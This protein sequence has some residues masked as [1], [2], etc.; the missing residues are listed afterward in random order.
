[1][2]LSMFFFTASFNLIIPELNGF[3]TQ[4]DGAH[5]KGLIIGLFTVSA[6][7]SRP[8]SGKLSDHI[9]RKKVMFIGG[10][11]C[12]LVSLLYPISFSIWFFLL[13][14]FLHGFSAGFFPTGATALVTDILPEETRGTGMG[15]WGTFISLGIGFGQ[16]LSSITASQFGMNGLFFTA[17]LLSVGSILLL[18]KVEE[19]LVPVER[20]QSKQLLIKSDEIIE[21]NVTPVAII[22]FLSAICSGIII[23]LSPE[24]SDFLHIPAKGWFF[25][26]YVL[27]T[28]GIRLFAGKVSDKFGRRETLLVGMIILA[29]SMVIIGFSHSTLWFTLSAILFGVA[30]GISSPT[31][32]AWT[33]DLSPEHRR[34]IGAGT[35]FIALEAGVFFGSIMTN[36][37]YNNKLNSVLYIFLVGAVMAFLCVVYLIWHMLNRKSRF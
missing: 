33:A 37:L 31:I 5:L 21:R 23:V 12:I 16:G 7:L 13:L 29:I 14:R 34:G 32:F 10:F 25:F 17:S 15:L 19:T 28:I 24:M 26:W 20:F 35:M 22:M 27:S 6:G 8:F 1:M 11:V 36:V 4:L 18:V 9:G 30:T 2:C 3:I